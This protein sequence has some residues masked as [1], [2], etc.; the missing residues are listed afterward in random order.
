MA[1]LVV[2]L[3]VSLVIGLAVATIDQLW[4][5]ERMHFGIPWYVRLPLISVLVAILW[6]VGATWLFFAI[7]YGL[8]LMAMG[9]SRDDHR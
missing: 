1:A 4:T 3:V 7:S 5:D 9:A 2:Y 8:V 6:P